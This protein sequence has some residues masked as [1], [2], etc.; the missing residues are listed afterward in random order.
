MAKYYQ[1]KLNS[2]SKSVNLIFGGIAIGLLIA[3]TSLTFAGHPYAITVNRWQEKAMGDN[4]YFPVL[5]IFLLALPPLLALLLI[6][7]IVLTLIKK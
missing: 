6:K 5:S 2:K 7:L 1:N 4:E 3:A